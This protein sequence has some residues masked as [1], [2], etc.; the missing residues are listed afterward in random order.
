SDCLRGGAIWIYSRIGRW[1]GVEEICREKLDLRQMSP[2]NRFEPLQQRALVRARRGE[3]GAMD[4]LDETLSLALANE[5]S[6]C[7]TDVRLARAEGGWLAGDDDGL[8]AEV[9]ALAESVL[10]GDPFMQGAYQRWAAR[11]GIGDVVV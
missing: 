11:C 7:V 10:S 1:D 8:R 3:D 4:L 6:G 2:I 5:S 9:V